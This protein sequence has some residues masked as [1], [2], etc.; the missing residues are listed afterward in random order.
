MALTTQTTKRSISEIA[1]D[2][3]NDWGSKVNPHAKPYLEAMRNLSDKN[4][5]FGADNATSIVT[6]FLSNAGGYR[7][8]KAKALK[9]ELKQFT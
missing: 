1:K 3:R 8:D 7:G 2:I 6:Y 5:M 9:A 4:D